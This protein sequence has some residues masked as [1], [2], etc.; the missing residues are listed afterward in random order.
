MWDL[1]KPQLHA[2]P[3]YKTFSYSHLYAHLIFFFFFFF[4][5]STKIRSN[6]TDHLIEALKPEILLYYLSVDKF[7]KKFQL[8]SFFKLLLVDF[9]STST[10][11]YQLLVLRLFSFRYYLKIAKEYFRW[12]RPFPDRH[13]VCSF[14][15]RLSI[16]M[17]EI[18][19]IARKSIFNFEV[20]LWWMSHQMRL[21]LIIII[22]ETRQIVRIF[23]FCVSKIFYNILFQFFYF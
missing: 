22:S 7:C 4:L 10:N 5:I 21:R 2:Q 20:I 19:V 12:N 16:S 17:N 11:K 3:F 15:L 14:C 13:R 8:F 9:R 6:S 18:Q 1:K 23:I